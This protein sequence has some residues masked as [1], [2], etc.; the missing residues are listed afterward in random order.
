MNKEGRAISRWMRRYVEMYYNERTD[1]IDTAGMARA[2]AMEHGYHLS[3]A[4]YEM[5]AELVADEWLGGRQS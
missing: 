3:D 5:Y 4:R 2:A 1:D